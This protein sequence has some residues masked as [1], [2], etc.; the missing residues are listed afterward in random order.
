M[1]SFRFQPDT[2][3]VLALCVIKLLIHFFSN[4]QYGFHRDELLYLALGEHLDVGYMEVPPFIAV[5]AKVS[6][7]LFG[8]SLFAMRLFP[9]V[10]GVLVVWLACRFARELGG[11]RF[12][13]LVAGLAVIVSP[14]FLRSDTLLQPVPFDQ[15]W[16]M[17]AAYLV[18]RHL[19]TREPKYWLYAGLVM[20]IGLMTKDTML[21]FG[22]GLAV[23]LLATSERRQFLTVWPWAAGLIAF[24]IVLPNLIWQI[25]HDWPF[26]QH[27]QKLNEHQLSQVT[28][29]QFMVGL[30]LIC[31]PALPVWI[32]GLVYFFSERGKAFRLFGWMVVIIFIA[33]L[34]LKA[35]SY[36]IAPVYPWLFAAGGVQLEAWL[37]KQS[38]PKPVL[39]TMMSLLGVVLLPYG[40]PILPIET[41]VEYMRLVPITTAR[42]SYTGRVENLPSDYADMFGWE[43][44]VQSIAKAYHALSPDE[45]QHCCILAADY[46]EAGAVDL[47]GKNYG[48]P[49]AI[50][51]HASYWLWPPTDDS[52]IE[53]VVAIGYAESSMKKYFEDVRQ[54]DF[55]TPAYT[56]EENETP[57]LLCRHPKISIV[58]IWPTLRQN[59]Y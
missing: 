31:L 15:L 13:V 56:Q 33:M 42:I 29:Q 37:K 40:V 11:G 57:V 45:Q 17:L 3:L 4:G 39:V 46:G 58:K 16:W 21:F 19:K 52:K 2:L 8:E 1:R 28:P 14:A 32:A 35:K 34:A 55:L 38:W 41:F 26:I 49:H 9:A 51:R 10:A 6:R 54:V 53:I 48:L 30:F 27:M 24:A 59:V 22:F 18:L 5:A 44:E 36:Y 25:R 7:V 23:A 12:A 43:E 20:G 50:S 47:Y